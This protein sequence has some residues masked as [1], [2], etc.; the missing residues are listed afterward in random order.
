MQETQKKTPGTPRTKY[1]TARRIVISV[2]IRSVICGII[3]FLLLLGIFAVKIF[4]NLSI[5]TDSLEKAVIGTMNNTFVAEDENYLKLLEL[6]SFLKYY[7]EKT[8]CSYDEMMEFQRAHYSECQSFVISPQGELVAGNRNDFSNYDIGRLTPAQVRENFH[9]GIGLVG[10][11]IDFMIPLSDGNRLLIT[12]TDDSF[13]MNEAILSPY[14]A[15]ASVMREN[16]SAHKDKNIAFV[17]RDD[18]HSFITD[19]GEYDESEMKELVSS[20]RDPVVS[21]NFP[22]RKHELLQI[23]DSLYACIAKYNEEYRMWSYFCTQPHAESTSD[24]HITL[25]VQATFF[26][27][28]LILALYVYYLQQ[29]S[30]LHPED[31]GYRRNTIMRKALTSTVIAMAGVGSAAFFAQTLFTLSSSVLHDGDDLSVLRDQLNSMQTRLVMLNNYYEN[32]NYELL[33]MVGEYVGKHPELWNHDS[34]KEISSVTSVQYFMLYDLEGNEIASSNQIRNY[35]FPTDPEDPAYKLNNLKSGAQMVYIPYADNLIAGEQS[36]RFAEIISDADGNG[37]GYLEFG[38]YPGTLVELKNASS[39]G[40][41]LQNTMLSDA[42][43]YVVVDPDSGTVNYATDN[44]FIGLEAKNLGFTEDSLKP[45]F[46]GKID[47]DGE[48]SYVSNGLVDNNLVF[49]V[50]PE[51]QVYLNRLPYTAAVVLL[52]FLSAAGIFHMLRYKRRGYS[53]VVF[54]S[55]EQEEIIEKRLIEE[56][57]GEVDKESADSESRETESDDTSDS[58]KAFLRWMYETPEKKLNLAIATLIQAGALMIIVAFLIRRLGGRQDSL[59]LRILSGRWAKGVNVFSFTANLITILIGIVAAAAVRWVLR[60]IGQISDARGE[61]ITRL[62]RSA[63]NYI[64]IITVACICLINLGLNPTTLMTSAGLTGV[65]IG[66]GARDLITD[67]VA[68]LFIIFEDSFHVGDIIEVGGY[69]GV[70]HEIGIRTTKLTGWDRNEK[71]INNRN[72]T[73]VINKSAK[74][75]FSILSFNIDCTEDPEKLRRLFEEEFKDYD[76]RYPEIISLPYFRTAPQKFSGVTE[77]HVVT[78][79][80]ELSRAGVER[81]IAADIDRLMAEHNIDITWTGM[82]GRKRVTGQPASAA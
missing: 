33:N 37:V 11:D 23:E 10:E 70:V 69:E 74:N 78:E 4:N 29:F 41:V 72:M 19:S 50:H 21:L 31:V 36:A 55:K 65:A 66:I 9:E 46:F 48:P 32:D 39:L 59:L 13:W 43:S 45:D 25:T 26:M 73:N 5:Q 6:G 64:A 7:I 22:D 14:E 40:S 53:R 47:I 67:I 54:A 44:A 61:T 3:L 49:M 77:C 17:Y 15:I 63:A 51:K 8:G 79:I 56:S 76:K 42:T 35:S 62:L 2:L 16:S 27:F 28:L 20:V 80:T 71:I 52:F 75:T 57:R 34:L 1:I 60:M 18:A 38:R 82:P 12:I 30:W 81:K 68:G 24:L 58:P